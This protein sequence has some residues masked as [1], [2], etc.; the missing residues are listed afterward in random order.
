MITPARW[1]RKT[2]LDTAGSPMS[3]WCWENWTIS[4]NVAVREEGSLI[5]WDWEIC[6]I[7]DGQEQ[8]VAEAPSLESAKR[9]VREL[10]SK[11]D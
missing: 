3:L 5:R 2:V 1:V 9:K 11:K 4:Q 8:Y 10:I 6:R 7:V